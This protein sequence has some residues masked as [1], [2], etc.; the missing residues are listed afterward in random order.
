MINIHN[1]I[2]T[3]ILIILCYIITILGSTG[4]KIEL[5][6]PPPDLFYKS[7]VLNVGLGPAHLISVDLNLDGYIDLV[8]AN[9]KNNTLSILL[10]NG[11][12]NWYYTNGRLQI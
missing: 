10:G 9:A 6:S 5:P 11:N 12:T 2:K 1:Q 3:K 4:C 8:S 7:N